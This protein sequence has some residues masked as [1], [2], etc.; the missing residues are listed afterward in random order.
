MSE[1]SVIDCLVVG[2]P[3]MRALVRQV[4]VP[5]RTVQLM[6][7]VLAITRHL[8]LGQQKH[9]IGFG[10]DDPEPTGSHEPPAHIASDAAQVPES[11]LQANDRLAPVPA[12]ATHWHATMRAAHALEQAERHLECHR[13]DLAEQQAQLAVSLEPSQDESRTLLAW[14]RACRHGPVADLSEILQVLTEALEKNPVNEKIRF[15]RA[16]LLMRMGQSAEAAREFQLIVALNPQ[17]IDAQR[18]LRLREIRG[19]TERSRSGEF[20][21]PMGNRASEIPPPPGLFGRIFRKP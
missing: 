11:S 18:E 17:H 14:I 19:R 6:L 20:R 9:P 7:Y 5:I 15:R 16:Q 4:T 12:E 2:I 3:D 1:E 21:R 13:Y 8:D 10:I